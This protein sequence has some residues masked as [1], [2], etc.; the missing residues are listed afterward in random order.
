MSDHR[1]APV[2]KTVGYETMT[3]P[4]RRSFFYHL[5]TAVIGGVVGLVPL[6]AGLAT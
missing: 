5:V 1:T 2:P 3:E 6:V 4:P